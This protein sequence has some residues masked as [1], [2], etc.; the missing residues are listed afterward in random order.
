MTV[1]KILI[2]RNDIIRWATQAKLPYYYRTGEIS[3]LPELERFAALVAEHVSTSR[4]D[5]CR[6][7]IAR[8]R[9]EEREACANTAWDIVQY[10][11]H[12][13][14]ADQVAAVIRARSQT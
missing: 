9:Q 11:V 4:P 6:A 12:A 8:A 3:N 10:E 7:A 14:L 1:D 5:G 2:D 13:D